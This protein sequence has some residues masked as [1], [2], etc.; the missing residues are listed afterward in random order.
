MKSKYWERTHKYGVCIPKNAKEAKLIDAENGNTLWQDGIT[1]EMKNNRIAFQEYEG[2][3]E[4]F[5]EM[6]NSDSKTASERQTVK[7]TPSLM[8]LQPHQTYRMSG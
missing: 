2:N 3:P 1:M 8:A 7:L 4:E 6:M 5:I